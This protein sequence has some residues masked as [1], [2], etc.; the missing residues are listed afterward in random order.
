MKTIAAIAAAALVTTAAAAP[1]DARHRRHRHHDD[2][3]AGDIV[4]GALVVG[5]V[6][7][8]TSSSNREKRARQD[9]AVGA[10]SDE[11]EYRS[12]GRLSEIIHVSR[13]RGYY[14]VEGAL[15]ADRDSDGFEQTFRCTVRDGRIYSLRLSGRDV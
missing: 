15:D 8:L 9:A 3:D 2:V 5:A 11:A 10:C 6:A 14:D 1:A 4:A 12:G 13:R 7:A